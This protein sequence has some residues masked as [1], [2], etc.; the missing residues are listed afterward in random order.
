MPSYKTFADALTASPAAAND[1]KP[2][3]KPARK[4]IRNNSTL[5]ALRWLYDNHPELAEPVADAVQSLAVS[6]WTADAIDN[7]QEIR[8]TVGELMRAATDADTGDALPATIEHDS[9]GNSF[10][11]I[12]AL[13]FRGNELVEYGQTKKGRKLQPRDRAVPRGEEAGAERNPNLY[14]FHTR[15][16]TPSPLHA[17]SLLRCA[18]VKPDL[19]SMYD[20]QSGVEKARAILESFGVDGTVPF[21]EMPCPATKCPPAI[22]K[23]AEFLGG[24]V[25]SSGTASSGALMWEGPE[26]KVGEARKVIEEVAARGTLQSIGESLGGGI[27][28]GK[29]ALVEAARFLVAANDNKRKKMRAA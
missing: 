20:P 3:A 14:V 5:P 13:K 24:V 8:P 11:L 23:G 26:A 17:T 10:I 22:A 15:P 7:D 28:E 25:Q 9:D 12:G 6:N 27:E 19:S 4:R 2:K 21:D 18:V 29:A 16:T 1:N